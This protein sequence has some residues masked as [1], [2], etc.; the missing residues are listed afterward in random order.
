ME[1][2][3]PLLWSMQT[4]KKGKVL[5]VSDSLV[6]LVFEYVVCLNNLKKVEGSS[7]KEKLWSSHQKIDE[8]I[9]VWTQ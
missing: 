4:S 2:E 1:E 5:L 6:N 8:N 3:K 7:C 9:G